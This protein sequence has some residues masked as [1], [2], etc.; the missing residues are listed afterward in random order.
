MEKD[1]VTIYVTATYNKPLNTYGVEP[2]CKLTWDLDDIKIMKNMDKEHIK[3]N[4]LVTRF[5]KIFMIKH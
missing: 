4:D 2:E 1:I 3:N 5:G